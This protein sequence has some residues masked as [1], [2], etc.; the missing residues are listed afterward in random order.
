MSDVVQIW[1]SGQSSFPGI[2][3]LSKDRFALR[4]ACNEER[5]FDRLRAPVTGTQFD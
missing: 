1:R 4:P 3:S 2:L 5:P